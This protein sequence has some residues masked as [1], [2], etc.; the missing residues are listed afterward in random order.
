[1][2]ELAIKIIYS[3]LLINF[4]YFI[5]LVCLWISLERK[6]SWSWSMSKKS[7]QFHSIPDLFP[8]CKIP[9]TLMNISMTVIL[10]I[11]KVDIWT[12]MGVVL[13][14]FGIFTI[15]FTLQ[16]GYL[17]LIMVL[18]SGGIMFCCV[19]FLFWG[20][21]VFGKTECLWGSSTPNQEVL[22]RLWI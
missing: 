2:I 12:S 22:S 7:R 11:K 15:L 18:P 20:G 3:P 21:L 5:I 17:G 16:C 8:P 6:I 19:F 1:M 4:Q 10:V 9:N 14:D 13:L